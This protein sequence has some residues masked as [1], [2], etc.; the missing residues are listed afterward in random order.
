MSTRRTITVT[1]TD[2]QYSALAGAIAQADADWEAE[3][4]AGTTE[5]VRLRGTLDRAWFAINRAWHAK[6]KA[7]KP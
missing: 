7:V 5:V 2:A 1:L 3:A 4:D 6:A